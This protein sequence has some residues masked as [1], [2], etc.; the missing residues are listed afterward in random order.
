MLIAEG[1]D[2]KEFVLDEISPDKHL[3]VTISCITFKRQNKEKIFV[4][5]IVLVF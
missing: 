1:E 5:Q 3:K 2:N 4:Y